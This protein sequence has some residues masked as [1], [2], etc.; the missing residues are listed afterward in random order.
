MNKIFVSTVLALSLLTSIPALAQHRGEHHE[1]YRGGAYHERHD[2]NWVGP[3]IIGGALLGGAVAADNCWRY[4][5][6]VNHEGRFVRKR[7]WT[8]D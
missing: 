2:N 8:C 1:G 4:R 6:Y 3:A 5:E 7:V